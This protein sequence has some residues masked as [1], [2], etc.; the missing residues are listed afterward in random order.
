MN[1]IVINGNLT[2]D[3]EVRTVGEMVVANFTIAN[4]E[5]FGDRQRTTFIKC[6][7]FGEKR[8]ESL[9]RFL[10]KGA[11]VLVD[12]KL[13]I[14]NKETEQGYKTYVSVIVDGLE[15]EKFKEV[16][17]VKEETKKTYKTYKK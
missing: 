17:Q 5:G 9:E 14:N 11:K 15:I 1:K 2:N 12:G 6:T 13:E 4:N 16:E 7:L 10:V 8:I 3:L